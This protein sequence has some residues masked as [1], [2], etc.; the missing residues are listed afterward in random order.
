ML[1]D[2]ASL[3]LTYK[4]ASLLLQSKRQRSMQLCAWPSELDL[5]HLSNK[6]H[7]LL[8]TLLD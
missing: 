8:L 5:R 1:R 7:C 4:S 6:T 3:L 2:V